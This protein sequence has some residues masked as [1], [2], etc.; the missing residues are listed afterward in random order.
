[1]RKSSICNVET[2]LV[3]SARLFVQEFESQEV[4]VSSERWVLYFNSPLE[5]ERFVQALSKVWNEVYQVS[6]F[7]CPFLVNKVVLYVAVV[8][9]PPCV[10]STV[11]R[12][13]IYLGYLAGVL[14]PPSFTWF[15]WLVFSS[16]PTL[17]GLPGWCSLPSQLYLGDLAG[18]L[19]PPSFTWFTWLVFSSLPALPRWPGWCSLPSQLYLVYLAGVLFPPSFA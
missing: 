5:M 14:F 10:R 2:E 19:F 16:L 8:L 4:G 9:S 12:I 11:Y 18:V 3:Y 7:F 13:I 6:A 15:T 17:P 1:M